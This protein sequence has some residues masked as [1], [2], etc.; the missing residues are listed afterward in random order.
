[1]LMLQTPRVETMSER[2]ERQL[3]IYGDT[4][5]KPAHYDNP[6]IVDSENFKQPPK[7]F[8]SEDKSTYPAD[9]DQQTAVKYMGSNGPDS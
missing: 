6:M 9:R 1:M 5:R 4:D 8:K 3:Y 7:E 2:I